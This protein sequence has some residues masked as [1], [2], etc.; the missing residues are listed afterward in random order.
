MEN[1]TFNYNRFLLKNLDYYKYKSKSVYTIKDVFSLFWDDFLNSFPEFNIR[2]VVFEEVNKALHCKDFSYGYTQFDCPDC[3]NFIL[4]PH[5][6]KSRFCSSCGNIYATS[7]AISVSKKC[8]NQKHRHLTFTIPEQLRL[9]FLK[10]RSLL[11]YLFESVDETI[12]YVFY[13]LNKSSSITPGFVL[14]LHTYGRDLKWNPHI[15]MLITEGGFTRNTKVFRHVNHFHYEVY[16]KTFQR[17]LLDKLSSSL[18]KSFYKLKKSLYS[19]FNNGFYVRAKDDKHKNIEDGIKYVVRYTGKP[20]MAE[21]RITDLDINKGLITYWYFDHTTKKQVIVTEHVFSF[22][23]KLIRHIP[24]RQFK[25]VR[26]YGLYCAKNHFFRDV[27]NTLYNHHQILSMRLNNLHRNRLIKDF[28]VDPYICECG[29]IMKKVYAYWKGANNIE[30]EI[31]Y[32]RK[33]FK[34][35]NWEHFTRYCPTRY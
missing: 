32:E 18:D 14:V 27:L 31:Y 10:D 1:L 26:Y 22:I 23:A 35:S 7:R 29:A 20:V 13:K 12:K 34:P 11:N 33:E 17:I 2:P 24:D 6:C 30:Y 25:M 5:T 16:R 21:S 4:I 3:N 8:I 9:F 28:D 19:S 15:H